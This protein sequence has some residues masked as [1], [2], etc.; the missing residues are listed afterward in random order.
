MG[1]LTHIEGWDD[2]KGRLNNLK[3]VTV[4]KSDFDP[5]SRPLPERQNPLNWNVLRPRDFGRLKPPDGTYL[6]GC[7]ATDRQAVTAYANMEATPY[8]VQRD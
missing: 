8:L 3:D 4:L 7:L 5:V 1:F 2:L 6:E